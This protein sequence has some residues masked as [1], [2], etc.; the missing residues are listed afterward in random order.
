MVLGR[1]VLDEVFDGAG[2]HLDDVITG[3]DGQR[4]GAAEAAVHNRD[5]PAGRMAAWA[6]NRLWQKGLRQVNFTI[7]GS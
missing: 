7:T 1:Q 2:C 6:G 5:A 4:Q 3:G